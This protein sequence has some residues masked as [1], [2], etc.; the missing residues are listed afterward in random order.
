MWDLEPILLTV[1]TK[2]SLFLPRSERSWKFS[3]FILLLH[4]SF[5]WAAITTHNLRL[6]LLS[7]SRGLRP[8][9]FMLYPCSH[10]RGYFQKRFLP[11]IGF[12]KIPVWWCFKLILSTCTCICRLSGDRPGGDDTTFK[13][14]GILANQKAEEKWKY[15]SNSSSNVGDREWSWVPSDTGIQS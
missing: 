8:L 7:A 10:I 4:T 5:I 13:R 14:K 11:T 3:Q 6:R 15:L 2:R 1:T 12:K 9:C